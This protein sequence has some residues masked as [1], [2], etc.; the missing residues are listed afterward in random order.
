MAYL[1][2]VCLFVCFVLFVCFWFW[3]FCIFE[4]REGKKKVLPWGDKEER[5]SQ[6]FRRNPR[7]FTLSVRNRSPAG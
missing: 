3:F 6:K 2:F 4:G 1:F 7:P 5:V